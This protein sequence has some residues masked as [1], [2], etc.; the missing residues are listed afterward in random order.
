M[1]YDNL[2]RKDETL[3]PLAPCVLADLRDYVSMLDKAL[4]HQ[5]KWEH[6]RSYIVTS[7]TRTIWELS[8]QFLDSS[9]RPIGCLEPP[10]SLI[11]WI[12]QTQLILGN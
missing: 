1:D 2:L 7:N 6:I 9:F 11:R 8:E 3:L 12:L 5:V 4:P 10:A